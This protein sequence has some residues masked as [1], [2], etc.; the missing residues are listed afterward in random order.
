MDT[1]T[2]LGPDRCAMVLP[3]P[4]KSESR[5]L[6]RFQRGGSMIQALLNGGWKIKEDDRNHITG[7]YGP[8]AYLNGKGA[9]QAEAINPSAEADHQPERKASAQP[10]TVEEQD[11]KQNP[12][13]S[14]EKSSLSRRERR[15]R[16]NSQDP[17]K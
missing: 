7:N 14:G 1:I 13:P 4:N 8:E 10:P 11:S 12:A 16:L 3:D 2:K 6:E 17:N 5:W 9:A 15:K